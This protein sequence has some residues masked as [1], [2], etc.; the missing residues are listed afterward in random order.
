[1]TAPTSPVNLL[2]DPNDLMRPERLAMLPPSRL[3]ASRALMN[4]MIRERWRIE[5]RHFEIDERSHGEAIYRIDAG[6]QLFEFIAFSFEP[7]LEGRTGRIIGTNWDMMGSLVEGEATREVIDRTAIEL[8]KLYAGRAGVSTLVWCRSNRSLRAFDHTVDRLAAGE[9][10]D[11]AE[12]ASIGYLMRNT[13]L[14]GNG[15][16]GTRSYLSLEPGHALQAPYHAQMLAAY[17]MREFS[18]DL[19]HHL[20]RLRSPDA[21]ELAPAM[22][23]YL[24][25]GNGSALG[26]VF[27][28][29]NHPVLTDRWLS[30]REQAL[31]LA[32]RL[33]VGPSSPHL[34][35]L[36][37]L[38]DRSIAY[39]GQDRLKYRVFVS[40]S[41]LAAGLQQVA[42]A[43]AA[44]RHQLVEPMTVGDLV[45]AV[46]AGVGQPAVEVVR[47][48]AIEL[49][50]DDADALVS[51]G[52]GPEVFI[53]ESGMT[54]A[55]L[56]RIIREEYTW[57]LEMDLNS[58]ESR[59][60]VWYK[61][62]DA[63]EPR[64]G[65]HWEVEGGYNWALD[66]PG[67]L[68]RLAGE[69]AQKPAPASIGEFLVR[70]P[71]ERSV[72]ERLQTLQGLR[73]HSPHMNMMD[74][75]FLPVQVIRLVNSAFHGLDKTVD[76][77]NRNV[78][79]LL[80]HGA[81]IRQ[82]IADGWVGDWFWP[83]E[84]SL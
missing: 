10:P 73:Y 33:E 16:F 6:G 2:G 29:N 61:S 8:P 63:E 60:F 32:F 72:V 50:P 26:L 52:G 40:P 58:E 56:R 13:G 5:L 75:E 39:F 23:R 17:M 22:R 44:V 3:S 69:L 15:T 19:V 41:E 67:D 65:P 83:V 7:K 38:V 68:Q 53:R 18:Y 62:R 57:A 82:E 42:E 51:L 24:G 49:V 79:G 46:T 76:F 59:Q 27:F 34:D 71:E 47:A 11:V 12:L 81:P 55:E 54:V 80:F 28:I 35:R 78:L 25:L 30:L 31:S 1:M 66:L 70:Y 43:L 84:P 21:V 77:L 14:D 48:L 37:A 45:A 74:A 64:R 36:A 4:R 20:A 9:Q